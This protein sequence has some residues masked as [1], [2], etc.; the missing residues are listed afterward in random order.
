MLKVYSTVGCG[1]CVML[2]NA[3]NKAELEYENAE[4]NDIFSFPVMELEDG[5]RL[6]LLQAFNWIK[7][8]NN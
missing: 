5:T 7:E 8:Q 6:D 2:K 1:K 4:A 3:L